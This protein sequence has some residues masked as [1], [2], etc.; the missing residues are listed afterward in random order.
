MIME[1][2]RAYRTLFYHQEKSLHDH[3]G[4]PLAGIAK[5]RKCRVAVLM[6][7]VLMVAVLM[8]TVLMVAV[9][10]AAARMGVASASREW[11]TDPVPGAFLLFW[12]A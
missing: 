10:M 7:A 2:L 1:V 12:G 5:F 9:L 4:A 6:V 3:D 11:F 8:V